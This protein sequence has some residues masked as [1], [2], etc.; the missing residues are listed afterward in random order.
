MTVTSTELGDTGGLQFDAAGPTTT[1]QRRFV[2][3][4][5]SADDKLETDLMA[6]QALASDRSTQTTQHWS[7]SRSV[8][9]VTPT[10]RL[11][12]V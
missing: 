4:A 7:A 1:T 8:A 10:T 3:K 9:S 2:V 11:Y 6:I 5:D 12:G